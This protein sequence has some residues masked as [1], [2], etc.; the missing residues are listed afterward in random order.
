MTPT[1]LFC[2]QGDGGTT[3]LDHH[4]KIGEAK[5][6][7]GCALILGTVVMSGIET[8][9]GGYTGGHDSVSQFRAGSDEPAFSLP[10]PG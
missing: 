4:A 9:L 8:V 5:T 10:R 7:L 6:T 2:R 3:G 1:K